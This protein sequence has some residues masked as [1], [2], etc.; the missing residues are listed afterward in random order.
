MIEVGTMS[1]NEFTL[2]KPPITFSYPEKNKIC[3]WYCC[4]CGKSFGQ[5]YYK[6]HYIEDEQPTTNLLD[7]L[8]YYSKIV[9]TESENGGDLLS[10]KREE[11]SDYFQVLP[12]PSSGVNSPGQ[13]RGG[14][15][16]TAPSTTES[17]TSSQSSEH[18][19]EDEFFQTEAASTTAVV[20]KIPTRFTCHRCDHMMCPYCPK[21]RFKDLHDDA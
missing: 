17:S 15:S 20:L 9:Y 11:S 8:K 7:R 1:T 12:L 6:D 4:L 13:S 3:Q 18:G 19:Y 21:V 16:K 2:N 14:S 10:M 5:I